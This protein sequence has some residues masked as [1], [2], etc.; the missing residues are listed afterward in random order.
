MNF[1]L[2]IILFIQKKFYIIT[3]IVI[4]ALYAFTVFVLPYVLNS[5]KIKQFA[6]KRIFPSLAS[7]VEISKSKIRISPFLKLY[8]NIDEIYLSNNKGVTLNL[9]GLDAKISPFFID[10][11]EIHIDN[12]YFKKTGIAERD[13]RK[14]N[15]LKQIAKLPNIEISNALLEFGHEDIPTAFIDLNDFIYK[16]KKQKHLSSNLVFKSDLIDKTFSISSKDTLVIGK[17]NI[18][19]DSLDILFNGSVLNIK[20]FLY[21]IKGCDFLI[22]GNNIPVA[23]IEG[24]SISAYRHIKNKK[25]FL[26]NFKDY[27]GLADIDLRVYKGDVYGSILMKKLS[28]FSIPLAV[29]VY[30]DK[31]LFKFNKRE[32]FM[33]EFGSFGGE[34][35]QLGFYLTGMFTDNLV[36]SGNVNSIVTEKFAEKY[37]DKFFIKGNV[38]LSVDYYIKD[39]I[40]NIIYSAKIPKDSDV[41]YYGARL[42]LQNSDREIQAITKKD[43]DKISLVDYSYSALLGDVIEPIVFGFGEFEKINGKYQLTDF[44]AQT[45]KDAPVSL[46]GFLEERLS[47]GFF[48]GNLHYD[49]EEEKFLGS[50]II[51]DTKFKNFDIKNAAVF[52]DK[53]LLTILAYGTL[54][55]EPFNCEIELKN[56]LSKYL[57][58]ENLILYLKKFVVKQSNAVK[59]PNFSKA[60]SINSKYRYINVKNVDIRIDYFKRRNLVLENLNL[61]GAVSNNVFDFIMPNILFA[62]GKLNASGKINYNDKTSNILFT[63]ND[64]DSNSAAFQ[65]FNL[66]DFIYGKACAKLN[67]YGKDMFKE[68]NGDVEF[69]IKEG[70]LKNIGTSGYV[71]N[72]T[73]SSPSLNYSLSKVI[74]IDRHVILN[75]KSN[76]TGRFKF[77]NSKIYDSD[78]YIQNDMLSIYAEGGFDPY[79]QQLDLIMWGKY[80]AD[81]EKKI[82]V[83]HI[84][85]NW[86]TKFAFKIAKFNEHEDAKIK[87]IPSIKNVGKKIKF[88]NIKVNGNINQP[89]TLKHELLRFKNII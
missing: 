86:I 51:Q 1:Y 26:E 78:I 24:A 79:N 48:N 81:V 23:D 75:P 72:K 21:D 22:T 5:H 37:I 33:N 84:P 31:A 55:N 74:K 29:P 18:Y 80:D 53:S 65:F 66:K 88:I 62:K 10:Q 12:L 7:K 77:A 14:D 46:L 13:K 43:A 41:L 40:V 58:I 89:K 4:L 60:K 42:G 28:A 8:L 82:T 49:F 25:N 36:I 30:F 3:G 83:F 45:K 69:S 16:G 54:D 6:V 20:G 52:G 47:G 19:T 35:A 38:L 67:L 15:F 11:G 57:Y 2:K 39:S 70:F 34:K 9:R 63:A 73:D 56:E 64:V 59:L 50:I 44:F 87:K 71:V 85:L 68:L 32:I 76:L 17:T 61:K 27:K